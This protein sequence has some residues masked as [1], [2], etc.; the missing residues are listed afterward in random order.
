VPPRPG[1]LGLNGYTNSR[2]TRPR[3]SDRVH[4]PTR[5]GIPT[6]SQA[7]CTASN[8]DIKQHHHIPAQ[9]PPVTAQ[10][11]ILDYLDAYCAPTLTNDDSQTYFDSQEQHE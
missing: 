4:H 8:T 7:H 2:N 6:Q 3:Y 9:L 5:P 10:L 11:S 1:P